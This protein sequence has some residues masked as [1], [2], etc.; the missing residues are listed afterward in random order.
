MS[1][2]ATA[3]KHLLAAGVTGDALIAAIAEM[4]ADM[5]AVDT[6][7]T[8]AKR[9]ARYRDR[10]AE[11]NKASQSVTCDDGVTPAPSLDKSP[12]DP[13]KLIPTPHTHGERAHVREAAPKLWACPDGVEPAHWRDF[14]G[15]RR[16]KKL[17]TSETA[18]LGQLKHLENF[19]ND[20]WPPGRLVQHAAEKGWGTIVNPL[21]YET[22][23]NG[24]RNHH[25]RPT[26]SR[27]GL[28][29]ASVRWARGESDPLGD[30]RTVA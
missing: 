17:G 14:L 8:A 6:R 11:R 23:R 1:V 30:E 24:Q 4:E 10:L 21:E 13:Q 20:E 7:S 9:Q 29:D 25:D 5:P 16:R 28:F 18:Y 26:G 27:N 3:V 22:P 2:I 12:P 19:A 15:N